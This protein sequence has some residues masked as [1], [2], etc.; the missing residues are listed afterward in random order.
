MSDTIKEKI[1]KDKIISQLE[2]IIKNNKGTISTNEAIVNTGHSKDE[3]MTAIDRL[4]ELY[5]SKA[6]LNE[7]TGGLQFLFKY[8]L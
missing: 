5:E 4:L 6:I 1:Q 3:I 8:P 7:T 2:Q